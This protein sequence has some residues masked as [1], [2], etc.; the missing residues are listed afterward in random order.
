L[1]ALVGIGC[2][3]NLVLLNMDESFG[4]EERLVKK[5]SSILSGGKATQA[6]TIAGFTTPE[7]KNM[8]LYHAG[9]PEVKKVSSWVLRRDSSG[10]CCCYR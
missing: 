7:R 3:A 2:V 6:M 1:F 10:E 8:K 5:A 9:G 4:R